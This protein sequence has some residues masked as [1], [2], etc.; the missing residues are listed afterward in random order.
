MITA[1]QI[2]EDYHALYKSRLG[3]NYP[4]FTNPS[5]REMFRELGKTVRF[6]ADSQTKTVYVWE[7][8][9]ELHPFFR[10][11][12]GIGCPPESKYKFWCDLI[13]EGVAEARGGKYVMMDSDG[14]E[15]KILETGS[16]NEKQAFTQRVLDRDWT[17]VNRYVEV[18]SYLRHLK[19]KLHVLF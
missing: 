7:A 18:T 2:L 4:V 14:L 16:P 6:C 17:W 10:R 15:G 12:A 11:T 9:L 19:E 13:L 5:Y 1:Q 3:E 8:D